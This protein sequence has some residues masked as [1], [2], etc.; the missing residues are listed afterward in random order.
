MK[1]SL[2]FHA[3]LA[4]IEALREVMNRPAAEVLG[5]L[6]PDDAF[7][8]DLDIN[9]WKIIRYLESSTNMVMKRD[10][11]KER[12]FVIQSGPNKKTPMR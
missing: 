6:R 7:G 11:S 12:S 8:K 3:D 9:I 1:C 2:G 4:E 10:L 5:E